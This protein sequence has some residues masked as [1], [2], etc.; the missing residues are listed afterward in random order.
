MG[1]PP[2]GATR[3]LGVSQAFL[4]SAVDIYA[5]QQPLS[6]PTLEAMDP[7]R[8]WRWESR[9]ILLPTRVA[10]SFAF[11]FV[12][13]AGVIRTAWFLDHGRQRLPLL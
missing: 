1:P 3:G 9:K 4:L 2:P 10:G 13:G 8:T 12:S 6:M 11:S 7:S 5:S